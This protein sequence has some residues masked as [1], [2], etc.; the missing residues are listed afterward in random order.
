MSNFEQRFFD[1]LQDLA[2]VGFN[3]SE[4]LHDVPSILNRIHK[5]S[6]KKLKEMNI[7]ETDTMLDFEIAFFAENYP[8]HSICQYAEVD[9]KSLTVE[10][11][12]KWDDF[13]RSAWNES[14]H[15]GKNPDIWNFCPHS[16]Y[17]MANLKDIMK[18]MKFAIHMYDKNDIEQVYNITK[19]MNLAYKFQAEACDNDTDNIFLSYNECIKNRK[20]A[21]V[22]G[23]HGMISLMKSYSTILPNEAGKLVPKMTADGICMAWIPVYVDVFKKSTY[24]KAFDEIFGHKSSGVKMLEDN[25]NTFTILLDKNQRYNFQYAKDQSSFK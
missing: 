24:Q 10:C 22:M 4:T 13:E 18:I 19:A 5:I 20:E 25:I 3:L 8:M 23:K 16:K 17:S 14:M 21:K 15:P 12:E 6:Y 11:I 7:Q 9:V 2:H 1:V